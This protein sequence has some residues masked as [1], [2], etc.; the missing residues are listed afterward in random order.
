MEAFRS[1][2]RKG[3]PEQAAIKIAYRGNVQDQ[4]LTGWYRNGE[5]LG[6]TGVQRRLESYRAV[7]YNQPEGM[8]VDYRC[9]VQDSDWQGWFANGTDCGTTNQSKAIY[10]IELRL[11]SPYPGS[12]L[13]YSGHFANR[14]WLDYASD[15][16]TSVSILGNPGD[17]LRMEAMRINAASALP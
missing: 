15:N 9:Y 11:N 4:G 13:T 7:L 2:V 10:A 6:T 8:Q 12:V 16:P 14:G 1:Y 17:R 3:S 5:Q